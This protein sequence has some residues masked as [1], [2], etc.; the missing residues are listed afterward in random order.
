MVGTTIYLL[1]DLLAQRCGLEPTSALDPGASALVE[2]RILAE[3]N[4]GKGNLKAVVWITH[5]LEQAQRVGTRYL[6][7][8]DGGCQEVS[9]AGS[10][11]V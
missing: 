11:E 2:K 10:R 6:S 8:V 4:E 9:E 7:L 3:V 5:S 1:F